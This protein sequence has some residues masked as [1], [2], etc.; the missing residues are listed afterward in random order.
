[1]TSDKIRIVLVE[2]DVDLAAILQMALEDEGLRVHVAHEG[3]SG[4]ELIEEVHPDVIVTDLVMP[5]LDG[6]GLIQQHCGKPGLRAPVI[7]VSAMGSRLRA[8]RDLGAV[9]GLIKPVPPAELAA[10]VRKAAH[11]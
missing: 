8:A 6:L 9:E 2:D 4:L 11:R 10:V 5:V 1:M 7:A 3:R